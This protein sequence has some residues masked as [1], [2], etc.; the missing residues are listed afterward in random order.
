MP[1][2]PRPDA[3]LFSTL[4]FAAIT[5]IARLQLAKVTQAVTESG[6]ADADETAFA[7]RAIIRSMTL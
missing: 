4:E 3:A 2:R 7:S 1:S 6:E 5:P